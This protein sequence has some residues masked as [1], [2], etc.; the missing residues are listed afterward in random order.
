MY[1]NT[2]ENQMKKV[3]MQDIADKLN[4]SKSLV[5]LALNNK[6]GVSNETRYEILRTAVEMGFNFSYKYKGNN[7]NFKRR[8]P[9]YINREELTHNTYW[10]GIFKSCERILSEQNYKLIIEVWDEEELSLDAMKRLINANNEGILVINEIP[11]SMY[12]VLSKI[13]IPVVFVDGKKYNDKDF[14][15]VRTNSYLGGFLVAEYLTQMGHKKIAFV[16]DKNYSISFRERYFGFKNYLDERGDI[17]FYGSCRQSTYD[18][19]SNYEGESEI[20]KMFKKEDRPTA[21]FC[22]NDRL[23]LFAY[24]ELKKI[25]LK[26]FDDVSIVGFDDSKESFMVSPKLT[27][28]KIPV[29]ELGRIAVRLLLYRINHM[30]TPKQVRFTNVSLDIKESVRRIEDV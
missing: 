10:S 8:I 4:I 27:S 18:L 13:N 22:A 14:D 29:E 15:N 16:G 21:I 23:A 9:V 26:P 5:S 19:S 1:I 7:K 12:K 2:F 24:G 30:D 20:V 6:Y 3:T 28:V 17:K 25:G 11:D